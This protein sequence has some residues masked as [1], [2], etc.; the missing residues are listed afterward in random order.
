[1]RAIHL[2]TAAFFSCPGLHQPHFFSFCV[3][4]EASSSKLFII[5]M[6]ELYLA[7][8]QL[9]SPYPKC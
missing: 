6:A 5:L 7:L 8:V 2:Q 4:L 1:M 3:H 9:H